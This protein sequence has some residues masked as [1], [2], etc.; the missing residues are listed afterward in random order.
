MDVKNKCNQCQKWKCN[1]LLVKKEIVALY[2]S[3]V[4]ESHENH[5][6]AS[7]MLDMHFFCLTRYTYLSFLFILPIT[8]E[9]NDFLYVF[10][11]ITLKSWWEFPETLYGM[12]MV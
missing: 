11:L 1:T 2:C 4:G 5:H 12:S 8:V 10:T 9:V 6:I 3:R 7:I